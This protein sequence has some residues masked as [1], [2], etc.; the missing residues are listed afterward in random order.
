MY[1]GSPAA[2]LVGAEGHERLAVPTRRLLL[3][4]VLGCTALLLL[5]AGL[6]I[7]SARRELLQAAL[8]L[9]SARCDLNVVSLAAHPGQMDALRRDLASA[10]SSFDA[11]HT[12][13]GPWA[14]ALDHLAWVPRV[15]SEL[16]AAGPAADTGRLATHSAV[17]LLDG[18]RPVAAVLADNR[19]GARLALLSER[20]SR[21]QTLFQSAAEDA[22]SAVASSRGL[23]GS[24][25]NVRL[26]ALLARL[27]AQLPLLQ[28]GAHL[29]AAAPALLG[30]GRPAHYLFT[31]ENPAELRAAGGFIGAVDYLTL[32][33]GVITH[34]F[35]GHILPHEI[36]T[37]ALPLPEAIYTPEDYLLFC[38]SNWSPDFPLSARLERWFYGED[39]GSWAGGVINF[40]D[41]G[42]G[43]L[44]GAT[45]PVYLPGY[46]RWITAANVQ[47]LAQRY[48]NGRYKGPLRSGLPE[49]IRKQFFRAVMEALLTRL[50]HL[51]LSGLPGLVSTVRS[52]V[53]NHDLLLYSRDPGLEA[54]IARAGAAGE[55]RPQPGDFL[56]VV[57]DNRSYNKLNS[58]VSET[59]SYTAAVDPTGEIHATLAMTYSVRHSP[60]NLEGYGPGWGRWGTKHDYQDFIRVYVPAGARLQSLA[61][62]DLWAPQAA[63]GLTQ[64]A[65]RLLVR[66]GQTR[67]VTLRYSVP[68]AALGSL[69]PHLYRLTVQ[70]QP[71]ADLSHLTI[72]VG[73][74]ATARAA[75]STT[76]L[77]TVLP[78]NGDARL[79][80]AAPGLHAPTARLPAANATDPYLGYPSL[81]DSRHPL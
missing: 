41:S 2:T 65:A 15:G 6:Q 25:H 73:L 38:D 57:D 75:S 42:I 22:D 59:G 70:R 53:A 3:A 71:G 48:I 43:P 26:D 32:R 56:M 49:T 24:L 44:L 40:V 76:W 77:R 79:Q 45:G 33:S 1:Q 31:W 21:S 62:A 37:A 69:P 9:R 74:P 23:P 55:L 13:L 10:A 20:L 50:Q 12:D 58:Y 30:V 36:T 17:S 78:L 68:P 66:A 35:Y 16:A 60:S 29:L 47:G 80:L 7:L 34:R 28:S 67:T 51:P 72:A 46:G 81:T 27:Q 39:T 61:G 63:Y 11:A 19:Q 54:Q 14:I 8:T 64:F 5:V 52:L 4:C 18:L